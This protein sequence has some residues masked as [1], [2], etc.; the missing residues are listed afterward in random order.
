M[1]QPGRK[2]GTPKTGGRKK[3]TPNKATASLKDLARLYT[4]DALAT[5]A[6]IMRDATAPPA[7]RVAASNSLLDRGYGKPPQ[8]LTGADD[9]PLIP[10]KT[11]YELHLPGSDG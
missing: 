7:A 4:D 5:L 9:T 6:F 2:K 1:A 3:G 10:P 8:A 11:V